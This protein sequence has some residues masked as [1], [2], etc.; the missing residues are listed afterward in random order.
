MIRTPINVYPQNVAIDVTTNPYFSFTFS[1]NKLI[2]VEIYIYDCYTE[3][4]VGYVEN[5]DGS[6]KY[7]YWFGVYDKSKVYNNAFY[8]TPLQSLDILTTNGRNYK[9]GVRI[10]H[11]IFDVVLLTGKI[12]QDSTENNMIYVTK[13]LDGNFGIK[14]PII[15]NDTEIG[16]QY[17]QIEYERHKIIEID[18]ESDENYQILLHTGILHLEKII[19]NMKG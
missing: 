4:N 16:C 3:K 9:W 2:G 19:N 7:I 1:G 5:P 8:S 6:Y 12:R 14:K 13:G 17:L 18:N 10:F 11:D 15:H